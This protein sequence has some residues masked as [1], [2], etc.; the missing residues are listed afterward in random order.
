MGT[1]QAAHGVL[2]DCSGSAQ[3][4]Q[5]AQVSWLSRGWLA[6]GQERQA[7]QPNVAQ[8]WG[9]RVQLLRELAEVHKY[10]HPPATR[11]RSICR[12]TLC[13]CWYYIDRWLW[14][15]SL[16]CRCRCNWDRDNIRWLRLRTGDR[17]LVWKT[18]GVCQ[19]LRSRCHKFWVD[20]EGTRHKEDII[21]SAI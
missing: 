13:W 16:L 17:W 20:F 7:Y 4:A 8:E 9:I 14:S 6:S 21:L 10:I 12:P 3:V 15:N 5:T 11:M 19:R 2:R 18:A 1:V